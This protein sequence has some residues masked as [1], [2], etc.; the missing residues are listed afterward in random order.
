[1]DLDQLLSTNLLLDKEIPNLSPLIASQL[2]NL[3]ILWILNNSSIT[4]ACLLE[5]GRDLLHV[6]LWWETLD[7]C[8]SL[9]GG[10]LLNPDVH[11]L[12]LVRF[13]N[14]IW[15]CSVIWKDWIVS[16]SFKGVNVVD[17]CQFETEP[18]VSELN[19]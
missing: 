18:N 1:M 14:T 7:K 17:I 3:T 6:Q 16:D 15:S 4:A 12:S 10:T 13:W 2:Q 19:V 5:I 8:Q 11:F 9:L